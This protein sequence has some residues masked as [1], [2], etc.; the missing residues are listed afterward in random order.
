MENQQQTAIAS[1]TAAAVKETAKKRSLFSWIA[2]A[3]KIEEPSGKT[4]V[5]IIIGAT[6]SELYSQLESPEISRVCFIIRGRLVP[7]GVSR[8]VK[9]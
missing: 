7:F 3:E 5:V 8:K 2:I 9:I 6:K 1:T 4:P